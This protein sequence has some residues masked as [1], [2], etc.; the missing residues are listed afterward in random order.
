[1]SDMQS[2]DRNGTQPDYPMN[3]AGRGVLRGNAPA[4]LAR[5]QHEELAERTDPAAPEPIEPSRRVKLAF[6]AVDKLRSDLVPPAD[7]HGFVVGPPTHFG[8]GFDIFDP[9]SG[10]ILTAARPHQTDIGEEPMLL[11]AAAVV[12]AVLSARRQQAATA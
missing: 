10:L 2:A 8:L 4:D 6:E 11:T 9:D 12:H 5:E 3:Q 1:M 7:K